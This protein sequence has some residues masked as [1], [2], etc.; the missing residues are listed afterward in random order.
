MLQ[1]GLNF[2]RFEIIIIGYGD[3]FALGP[4]LTRGSHSSKK[5][6][7]AKDLA[8]RA[9]FLTLADFRLLNQFGK[10]SS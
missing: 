10:S 5:T 8:F 7:Q 4:K 9:S 3:H 2:L 1:G 6:T